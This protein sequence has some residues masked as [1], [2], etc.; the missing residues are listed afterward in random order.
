MLPDNR[1]DSER[2]V[3]EAAWHAALP[4]GVLNNVVSSQ[5]T[6]GNGEVSTRSAVS[7]VDWFACM[8]TSYIGLLRAVNLA[9]HNKIAMT[10][11]RELLTRIG[12]QNVQTLLQSGNV[13]FRSEARPAAELE[14][15]I[16]GAAAKQLA[17]ATDVLVRSAKEWKAII[18]EN[19]FPKEATRDPSHLLAVVLKAAPDRAKVKALQDAITGREI[20]D[21]HGPC[22]YIVYPD[23]IGRSRLTSAV[24]EKNLATRG[25]GRNWNT[26]L[27]LAALAA[28]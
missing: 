10:D 20:V 7:A 28:A 19:P 4:G 27:K 26:V 21:V 13:V 17:L 2:L 12:M 15:L 23:G 8:M 24:I 14:R 3:G 9:G 11:L 1:V 25:T 18:A 16:E 6:N 22:A 5:V